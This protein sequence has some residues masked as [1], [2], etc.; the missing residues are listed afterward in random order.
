MLVPATVT[1]RPRFLFTAFPLLIGA[2]WWFEQ[3]RRTDE[4]VWPMTMAA[5]GA[6]LAALT[7][8]YGV[9]GAIP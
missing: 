7:G 2:A 5:C 4:T 8:L 3:R 6:G 9:F 1:A